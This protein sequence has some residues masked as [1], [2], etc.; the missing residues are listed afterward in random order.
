ML[1]VNWPVLAAIEPRLKMLNSKSDLCSKGWDVPILECRELCPILPSFSDTETGEIRLTPHLWERNK[2]KCLAELKKLLPRQDSTE[3]AALQGSLHIS[4][5][6]THSWRPQNQF[7][8]LGMA[9]G[10]LGRR[11]GDHFSPSQWISFPSLPQ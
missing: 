4:P 3:A 6:F 11:G 9:T 5:Y 10:R 7:L 8:H 1:G 2:S